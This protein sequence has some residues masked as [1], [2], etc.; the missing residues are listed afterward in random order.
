[1]VESGE[2]P[3]ESEVRGAGDGSELETDEEFA[4]ALER[5]LAS[6]GAELTTEQSQHVSDMDAIYGNLRAHRESLAK[7]KLL[8]AFSKAGVTGLPHLNSIKSDIKNQR[9]AIAVLVELA[10]ELKLDENAVVP[11]P[12][13]LE[14]LSK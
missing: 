1:V 6:K 4:A 13:D 10:E 9:K 3:I 11:E 2:D 7:L 5:E 14:V 12:S 8:A